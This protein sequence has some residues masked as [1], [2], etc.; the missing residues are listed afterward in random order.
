MHTAYKILCIVHIKMHYVQARVC[1]VMSNSLPAHGLQSTRLLFLSQARIL[2]WVTI[3]FS[4]GSS[5]PRD[6]THI[7]CIYYCAT[8]VAQTGILLI[9]FFCNLAFVLFNSI[10]LKV[11]QVGTRNYVTFF[12]LLKFSITQLWH[13]FC[14]NMNEY[15]W[16]TRW[17]SGLVRLC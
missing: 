8:W 9:I 3:S 14:N 2:E 5:Q 10:Y 1:L 15:M 17:F 12:Y 11:P 13:N 6:P 4:R 16:L 7:S